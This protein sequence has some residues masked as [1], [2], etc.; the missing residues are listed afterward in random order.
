MIIGIICL[1]LGIDLIWWS[2]GNLW[3]LVPGILFTA[4]GVILTVTFIW[5]DK[6]VRKSKKNS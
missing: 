1:I 3:L 2:R 5:L 6:E 4:V